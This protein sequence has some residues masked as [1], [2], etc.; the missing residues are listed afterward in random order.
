MEATCAWRQNVPQ[1]QPVGAKTVEFQKRKRCI[2]H[3]SQAKYQPDSMHTPRVP[4]NWL[5][6]SFSTCLPSYEVTLPQP[7]GGEPR[8]LLHH[9]PE[10]QFAQDLVGKKSVDLEQHP[11]G[12]LRERCSL[13]VQDRGKLAVKHEQHDVGRAGYG[14]ILHSQRRIYLHLSLYCCTP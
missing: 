10:Q 2:E 7:K 12:N 1:L 13:H 3:G 5:Q 6:E 14:H 4:P 9:P 8:A 11:R